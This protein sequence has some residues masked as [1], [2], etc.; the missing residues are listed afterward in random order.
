MKRVAIIGTFVLGLGGVL[1]LYATHGA[2]M[3]VLEPMGPI[4]LAEK[5]VILVTLLLAS[6]G[7]GASVANVVTTGA[8][9]SATPSPASANSELA[10]PA[11]SPMPRR[12]AEIIPARAELLI[13]LRVDR[14]RATGLG[15][16]ALDL[17]RKYH[18]HLRKER[19]RAHL[20]P[21]R[22]GAGLSLA[23]R[24][25]ERCSR[26]AHSLRIQG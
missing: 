6:L 15:S 4:A 21:R 23:A 12:F 26:W 13:R 8:A 7:C 11:P 10:T 22:A 20:R 2:H 1:M 3:P 18:Q 9:A 16:L 19:G 25:D 5:R 17:R 14:L 24:G